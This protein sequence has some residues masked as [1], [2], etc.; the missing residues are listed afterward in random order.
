MD[1]NTSLLFYGPC[2]FISGGVDK[3]LFESS[4]EANINCVVRQLASYVSDISQVFTITLSTWKLLALY[5]NTVY[6]TWIQYMVS[7]VWQYVYNFS[8]RS[9]S[10]SGISSMLAR[11][12]GWGSGFLVSR[13]GVSRGDECNVEVKDEFPQDF[14]FGSGTSAYQVCTHPH[15]LCM[16]QISWKSEQVEGAAAEDA[17]TPSIWDTF[18]FAVTLQNCSH[19]KVQNLI[20]DVWFL[21][22]MP[23]ASNGDVASDEYHKY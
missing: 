23:G 11:K 10:L 18:A 4:F 9:L 15:T 14:V 2:T 3:A 7:K 16:D 22:R 6:Y 21:G 20:W 17:R 12:R 5:R 19:R 8:F 13:V 1:V